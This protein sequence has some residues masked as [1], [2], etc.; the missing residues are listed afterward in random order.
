MSIGHRYY[1][2]LYK[3]TQSGIKVLKTTEEVDDDKIITP[4]DYSYLRLK[5]KRKRPENNIPK[6]YTAVPL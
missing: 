6:F 4:N 3:P 2:F 1:T 5:T